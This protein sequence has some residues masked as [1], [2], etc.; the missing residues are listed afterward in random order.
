MPCAAPITAALRKHFRTIHLSVTTSAEQD[1]TSPPVT[2]LSRPGAGPVYASSSRLTHT[3]HLLARPLT[4]RLCEINAYASHRTLLS[5]SGT[6]IP[7]RQPSGESL[8]NPPKSRPDS[9]L[10]KPGLQLFRIVAWLLLLPTA[11]LPFEAITYLHS[12]LFCVPRGLTLLQYTDF[13]VRAS[14]PC[15]RGLR[16]LDPFI[17]VI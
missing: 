17:P 16:S 12:A 4:G 9:C 10:R 13:E 8:P 14:C 6:R 5:S 1:R 15:S 11:L 7:Q 2:F 3:R